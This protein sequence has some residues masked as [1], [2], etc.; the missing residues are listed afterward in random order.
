M[1]LANLTSIPSPGTTFTTYFV[2]W[3]SSNGKTYAT[4]TDVG[5]GLVAFNWGEFDTSRNPL[6]TFNSTTGTFNQGVNGTITVN[7]PVSGVGNPTIP[8]TDVNGTPAVSNPYGLT[9]AGE[10]LD[11]F[12]LVFT[13]PM[14]RAPDS[15][16]GQRWAV[17]PPPNAAPTAVLTATPTSG[18]APLTVN[19]NGS[20]SFD[21]DGDTIASYTFDFGDGPAP[22][23]QSTPTI[24]HT[25]QFA[26]NYAATL[27]VTDSRGLASTNT[28]VVTIMVSPAGVSEI[29]DTTATCSTFSSGTAPSLSTVQYS[30]SNGKIKQTNPGGFFYWVKVPAQ[31]GSNTFV[32]NQSITTGNFNTFFSIAS[33]S[34]TFNSTCTN[35]KGT[36]TQSSTTNA[37]RNTVTATFTAPSAGN[38]VIS[39]KFNAQ[40]VDGKTVPNPSTVGY[41]FS[42]PGVGGSTQVLNLVKK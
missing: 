31:K 29:T 25:Y 9:I 41:S 37:T 18:T 17:C 8:I 28:A 35:V 11:G 32:I 34:I 4:E 14:D 27:T 13:Q 30:V 42:I 5:F 39:V 40:S 36:F 10:G 2:V 20:G 23:T 38:Y 22:V 16:F 15:G 7:V 3:T 33:G 6:S 19:F 21:S 26:G 12:G 1:T 24:S